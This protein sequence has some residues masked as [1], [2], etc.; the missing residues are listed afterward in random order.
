M[1]GHFIKRILYSLMGS[2]HRHPHYN[3][4]SSS[5]HK[6]HGHRPPHSGHHGH[7]GHYGNTYY[8]NR[9]SSFSS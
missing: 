1:L 3:R 9:Y 2:K 6:H 8:K 4:Y 5:A 7:H